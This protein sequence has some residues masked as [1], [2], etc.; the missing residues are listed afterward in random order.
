MTDDGAGQAGV[1]ISL[2]GVAQLRVDGRAVSLSGRQ[3]QLLAL[4]VTARRDRKSKGYIFEQ[5]YL[6]SPVKTADSA[7]RVVRSALRRAMGPYKDLILDGTLYGIDA[8]FRPLNVD[9]WEFEERVARGRSLLQMGKLDE[10]AK[11]LEGADALWRGEA[12]VGVATTLDLEY[13]STRLCE[14]RDGA[15]E[16]LAQAWIDRNIGSEGVEQLYAWV[17]STPDR[18]RLRGLLLIA[19]ARS[20][21][22]RDAIRAADDVREY[23]ADHGLGLTPALQKVVEEVFQQPTMRD[24]PSVFPGSD[25][26]STSRGVLPSVLRAASEVVVGRDHVLREL[27][28]SHAAVRCVTGPPGIGKTAVLAAF[29]MRQ[30]EAASAN[31]GLLPM[32]AFGGCEPQPTVALGP[33]SEALGVSLLPVPANT[34]EHEK[35][36]QRQLPTVSN[37]LAALEDLVSRGPVVLIIDDIQWA[38]DLTLRLLRRLAES[39]P[40]RDLTVVC[41]GRSSAATDE[42]TT[43]SGVKAIALLPLDVSGAMTLTNSLFEKLAAELGD[44]SPVDIGS[45]LERSVEIAGGHPL[46]LRS[47]A[48]MLFSQRIADSASLA[49]V[50][51][52]SAALNALDID[53]ALTVALRSITR[54]LGHDVQTVAPLAA[55]IGVTIDES[56]IASAAGVDLSLVRQV[57]DRLLTVGILVGPYPFR[58]RHRSIMDAL[59]AGLG[60]G[61]RRLLHARIAHAADVDLSLRALHALK[62]LP[63]VSLVDA[64]QMAG[65]ARA[66]SRSTSDYSHLVQIA[67]LERSLRAADPRLPTSP[68][69]EY[70][71]LADLLSGYDSLGNAERDAQLREELLVLAERTGNFTWAAEAMLTPPPYGRSIAAG[72]SISGITRAI[73]LGQMGETSTGLVR[74]RAERLHRAAMTGRAAEFVTDAQFLMDVDEAKVGPEVWSEVA[75]ALLCADFSCAAA[76]ERTTMTQRLRA[77]TSKVNDV[78]LLSDGFALELRD[79]IECGDPD[80]IDRGLRRIDELFLGSNRAVDRWAR[81]IT[82]ATVFA[83]RGLL[84]QAY[85]TAAAAYRQGMT[86]GVSD[87]ETSW[88]IQSGE[89]LAL[90]PELITLAPETQPIFALDRDT[91][92]ADESVAG[93]LVALA[94]AMFAR[95][96]LREGDSAQ[97]QAFLAEARN[98]FQPA[99]LDLH[100][101][102]AAV[103]IAA[104]LFECGDV[105]PIDVEQVLLGPEAP[106]VTVGMVSGWCYGPAVRFAAR[107]GLHGRSNSLS[108]EQ[109]VMLELD[110]LSWCQRAQFVT[111]EIAVLEDLIGAGLS[112]AGSIDFSERLEMLR[113]RSS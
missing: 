65:R 41:A 18:Q 61:P 27:T 33:V 11:A 45:A 71:L 91:S 30:L 75:R 25:S 9:T 100:R 113:L 24:L 109:A 107:F 105:L 15:R 55:L 50:L 97:A 62:A 36:L 92:R 69:T 53:S 35:G 4:L 26:F 86:G 46:L 108:R 110:C 111:F 79:A 78:D 49:D 76:S 93:N 37:A 5:V 95:A 87:T 103:L 19:L 16:D 12:M 74:L 32:I 14:L 57:V 59:V 83:A 2:L 13:E 88:A 39:G 98:T 60:D 31:N 28:V 42:L 10:A 85:A 8:D 99:T 106:G 96:S 22:Q 6:G 3:W 90:K 72:Q 40:R 34:A 21:R 48:T 20:G 84:D 58:F 63:E 44:D 82:R 54:D 38:D 23:F 81:L 47:V 66:Q 80:R 56:V 73:A 102:G 43:R 112:G 51:E 17:R 7:C 52:P 64:I 89:L 94:F 1:S 68:A 29:A 77:S 70:E 101:R 104:S 67:E